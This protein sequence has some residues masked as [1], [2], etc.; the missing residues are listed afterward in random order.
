MATEKEGK[1]ESKAKETSSEVSPLEADGKTALLSRVNK[2]LIVPK[3]SFFFYF[4]GI[5]AFLPYLGV[6]YKQLWLNARET[7]I[8]LGIRP[9]IK[10]LFSPVW[11]IITDYFRKPKT[12]LLLSIFAS[13][14]AHWSQSIV[15]P[16]QLPCYPENSSSVEARGEP[17][18]GIAKSLDV[19]LN[20]LKN[21]NFKR[22]LNTYPLRYQ[23]ITAGES[24][25]R[26]IGENKMAPEYRKLEKRSSIFKEKGSGNLKGED[27][28]LHIQDNNQRQ[29]KQR[30]SNL[31]F[32]G[33]DF[34][35]L[36][37]TFENPGKSTEVRE[38]KEEGN[39]TSP[40]KDGRVTEYVESQPRTIMT[41]NKKIKS[42]KPKTDFRIRDNKKIFIILLVLIIFGEMVAAPAPMLTDSGTLTLLSGREH[43]Y[44]KQRLFGSLGWGTGA[45]V[46][47]AVVTAFHYCPYSDNINYVPIFYVFAAAMLIDLCV[48]AFFKFVSDN[49]KEVDS[50]AKGC[51]LGLKLFGNVKNAAFIFVLFFCGLSHSLKL[52]FLFWFLQDIGG[53]PVLFTLI[54]LINSLSEVFMF[55]FATYIVKRVGHDAVLYSGLW[56][57]G[58]KFLIYSY[59]KNPWHVLP[60]ESL[61]GVTYGL[62]WTA[63]VSYVVAGPGYGATIQG[64]IHGVYWGLG[65]AV[66]GVLGGFLVHVLGARVTFRITAG[67]SLGILV[68]FFALNNFYRRRDDYMPISTEPDQKTK[69]E[70]EESK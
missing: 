17:I 31:V 8:L 52:S 34:A 44:G 25:A 66:G 1:A 33:E 65:M 68:L 9:F 50:D 55:F 62:V 69:K 30:E 12:I 10:M 45:L 47:G 54:V 60:L 13:L 16:F 7:G 14:I 63:S 64:I 51:I 53:T 5:G 39:R 42:P 43:E 40:D 23:V 29:T 24:I 32:S 11:G 56:C 41:K 61:Q 2:D 20:T 28:N 22:E 19:Q 18:P 21:Q 3:L 38:K 57:Y 35:E 26:S 6:Y 59:I 58:I 46:A 49:E 48:S 67:C 15:S 4:M 36:F 27:K 37:E 70:S